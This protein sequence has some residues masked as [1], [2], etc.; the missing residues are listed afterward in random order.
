MQKPCLP[1][2]AVL[3]LA[4][5]ACASAPAAPFDTLKTANAT[6]FRL[7]NFEP[8]TPAPG[9]ALPAPGAPIPG[10]PPEIQNW[11][12]QGAQGLTQLIPPVLLPPGLVPGAPGT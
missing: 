2:L 11:I 9:A 3:S 8:P 5:A 10:L 1:L 4:G 6:A 12:Q 7:Q